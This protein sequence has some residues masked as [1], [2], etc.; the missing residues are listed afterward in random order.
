VRR[1]DIIRV[2]D[3]LN[4]PQ[5]RVVLWLRCHHKVSIDHLTLLTRPDLQ[6]ELKSG[7]KD[8][9]CP[10]CPDPPAHEVQ[11]AKPASQ[12]WKEAGEP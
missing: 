1:Q 3:M 2:V 9:D 11:A 10:F 5:Q 8:W 6:R 4:G 7:R 12:L